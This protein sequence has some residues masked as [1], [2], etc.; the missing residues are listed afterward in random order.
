MSQAATAGPGRAPRIA[1]LDYGIGNLRSAQRALA[2][3]G[4]DAVLV[5]DAA[6]ASGSDG[7]VL[8]GVGAFGPCASALRS[9][10]LDAVALHALSSGL[11][12]LGICVGLQLLY[13]R[14]EEDPSI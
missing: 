5:T 3:A 9:S 14:S 7:V 11:P 10:G 2:R 12:F 6:S 13:S 1:V 8:P 4:A